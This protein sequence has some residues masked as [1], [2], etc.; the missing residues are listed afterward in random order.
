MKIEN[1]KNNIT[2]MMKIY[3][4]NK[5]KKM[6]VKGL[7]KELDLV[8]KSTSAQTIIENLESN[9]YNPNI[10][11]YIN[12]LIAYVEKEIGIE[13]LTTCNTNIKSVSCVDFSKCDDY[14]CYEKYAALKQ[15]ITGE[16]DIKNN[17]LTAY[18]EDSKSHEL[19]HL[20]S[21]PSTNAFTNGK[22]KTLTSGFSASYFIDNSGNTM[23]IGT[24]FNEGCTEMFNIRIFGNNIANKTLP[25]ASNSYNFQILVARAK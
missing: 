7:S 19:L 15:N 18:N 12:T 6:M 11:Q 22:Q 24:N 20:C 3:Y 16:Y 8:S 14:A 17:I 1:C 5:Y 2:K 4:M 13:Y 23:D 21:S 9:T 25:Y 10:E